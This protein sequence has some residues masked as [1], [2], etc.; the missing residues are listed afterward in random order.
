MSLTAKYNDIINL[1]HHVSPRRSRMSNYQRA[2]QFAPFWALDGHKA[3]VLE[4]ERYVDGITELAGDQQNIIDQALRDIACII[5]ERPSVWVTYF[6]PDSK[7]QGGKYIDKTGQIIS[8]SRSNQ[9]LTFS[10]GVTIQ[11]SQ[12]R[13]IQL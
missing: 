11:F 10:D 3:M 9:S 5:E 1:P 8:I 6:E 4:T 2:A 13:T 7:K 12:L